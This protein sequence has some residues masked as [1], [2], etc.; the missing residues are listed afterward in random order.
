M[1]KIRGRRASTERAIAGAPIG[2]RNNGCYIGQQVLLDSVAT[3]RAKN[4]AQSTR[5]NPT[6]TTEEKTTRVRMDLNIAME[7]AN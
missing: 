7:Y 2:G 3:P 4:T 6:P 1:V 5:A